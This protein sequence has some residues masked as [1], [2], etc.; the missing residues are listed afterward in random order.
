MPLIEIL[1]DILKN[2]TLCDT[3]SQRVVSAK[4]CILIAKYAYC[5]TNFSTLLTFA[6]CKVTK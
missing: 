1:L 5:F 2:T 6:A 4:K 3:K